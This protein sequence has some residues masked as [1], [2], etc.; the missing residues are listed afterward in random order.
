MMA[1]AAPNYESIHWRPPHIYGTQFAE[2]DSYDIGG[3]SAM[4]RRCV[5]GTR[6]RYILGATGEG[7][8]KLRESPGEPIS[9]ID[10]VFINSDETVRAWLLSNPVLEDPLDLLVY[11]QRDRDDNTPSTPPMRRHAYL[12]D[13]AVVRWGR[14]PAARIG[15]MHFRTPQPDSRSDHGQANEASEQQEGDA[16]R[17]SRAAL[18]GS[19]SDVL[20]TWDGR[21]DG[22]GILPSPVGDQAETPANRIP[23]AAKSLTRV[24]RQQPLDLVRHPTPGDKEG[25]RNAQFDAENCEEREPK[26]IRERSSAR[27]S[28]KGN[29]VWKRGAQ[30]DA[31]NCEERKSKRLRGAPSRRV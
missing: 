28:L 18:S 31:E 2:L 8:R 17:L 7:R 14:D 29:E 27:L 23:F 26:R 19:S 25:K 30:F 3:L 13:N 21:E 24:N 9:S 11:C 1:N 10:Y 6:F 20:E 15:E 12:A 4:I 5:S 22:V 16:S